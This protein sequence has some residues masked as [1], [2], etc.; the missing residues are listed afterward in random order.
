MRELLSHVGGI[1]LLFL[2]A[3][4]NLFPLRLESRE[5]ARVLDHFGVR[6]LPLVALTALIVGALMVIQTGAVIDFTGATGMVG[7]AAGLA[8]MKE[9]GPVLIGIMFSGQVGSFNAAELG[10]MRITEQ[11]EALSGLGIDPVR[12]LVFPRMLAMVLMLAVLT[13]YG[14]LFAILG[15]SLLSWGM[16]R[17]DPWVFWQQFVGGSHALDLLMG[18]AKGGLFGLNIAVVS[19]AR[20]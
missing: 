4:A 2:R 17:L 18:V 6:S 1:T 3:L 8:V 5:F 15:G 19:T 16:F 14:D 10:L 11:V 12:F 7:W 9:V 20:W 13:V